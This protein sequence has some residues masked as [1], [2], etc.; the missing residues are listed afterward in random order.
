MTEDFGESLTPD[1]GEGQSVEE[2]KNNTL[3]IIIVIVVIVL[4]CFCLMIAYGGWWLW[5]NGDEI[6]GLASNLSLS[7]NSY[8]SA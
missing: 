2:K 3:W 8:F 6:F 1:Y 7:L 5:N 4:C